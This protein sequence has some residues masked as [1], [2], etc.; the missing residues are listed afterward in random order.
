MRFLC[1]PGAYGSV[2]KFKVQL[3][4]LVKELE[5][6]GTASFFF[7]QGPYEVTPPSGYEEFFGGPPY[8]RFIVPS[9]AD[10]ETVDVL[11]RIRD[12]PQLETPEM[13]MREL[14]TY[15]IAKTDD[16]ARQTLLYLYE[17]MEKEGPFD[18]IIG[19]SEGATIAGTLLLHEQMRDK[20][21]GR[22]PVLKCA[23]FFGG[24]PPMRPTLDGI[25]LADESDLMID[26]PTVHIVGSLDPYLHGNIALYNIC[27]PDTAFIFDHAKG[28]TLPRDKHMVKELGDTV[29]RMVVEV[30]G[31]FS[32]Y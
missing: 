5:S 32:P 18:G 8:Y 24:W 20:N 15:G 10:S 17:V 29:R 30:N 26:V 25:V 13:T 6:D 19:Y 1:L 2:E 12:F 23:L 16:S 14:M 9:D 31:G 11:E 4:P 27:D 22:I 28:H 3:A 7:L 21:E